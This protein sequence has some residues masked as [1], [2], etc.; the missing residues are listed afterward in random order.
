MHVV[1][2]LPH[3]FSINRFNHIS[4]MVVAKTARY[5]FTRRRFLRP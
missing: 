3:T 4:L 2:I 5:A 1:I